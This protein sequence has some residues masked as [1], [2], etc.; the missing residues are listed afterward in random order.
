MKEITVQ[1]ARA[2]C[3]VLNM[4]VEWSGP[5]PIMRKSLY[6]YCSE[7]VLYGF[8]WPEVGWYG[9]RPAVHMHCHYIVTTF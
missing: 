2:W 5:C 7:L 3:E 9:I 1:G 6:V 4:Y 8:Q